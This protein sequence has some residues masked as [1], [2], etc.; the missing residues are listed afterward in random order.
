M[1]DPWDER[2]ISIPTNL[3]FKHQANV[4][5]YTSPMELMIFLTKLNPPP[6]KKDGL[7]TQEIKLA[8]FKKIKKEAGVC[9]LACFFVG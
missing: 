5:K 6:L 9:F 1:T 7:Q 4:G 2:Y 8:T 3:P